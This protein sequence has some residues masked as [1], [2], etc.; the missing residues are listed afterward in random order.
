MES[1]VSIHCKVRAFV[2]CYQG[3]DKYLDKWALAHLKFQ[4]AVIKG[5]DL[6]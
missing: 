4:F 1:V 3:E 2:K 5:G 6:G